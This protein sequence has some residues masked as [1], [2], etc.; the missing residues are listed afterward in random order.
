[1][2][3]AMD[4]KDDAR[5]AV[6]DMVEEMRRAADQAVRMFSQ[7]AEDLGV[8]TGRGPARHPPPPSHP[9]VSAADTIRDLAR[10]RDEGLITEDEFQAKKTQL[11]E[12]I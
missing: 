5:A 11:L 2:V 3:T 9:P 8:W 1:M 12:R 6:R 4:A 10:L 7:A